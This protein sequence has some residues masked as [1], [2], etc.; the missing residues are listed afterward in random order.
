MYFFIKRS[1]LIKNS[2]N[3]IL[4]KN[5]KNSK[6]ITLNNFLIQFYDLFDKYLIKIFI[7]PI[8]VASYSVPQQLTGKLSVIS[9]SFSVFLLPNLA[10]KKIDKKILFYL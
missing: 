2:N 9:K 5:L 3:K 1:R 10:K 6:W 8:A 4:L 7:G